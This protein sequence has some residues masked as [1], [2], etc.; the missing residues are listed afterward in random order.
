MQKN[1]YWLLLLFLIGMYQP[2]H[3]QNPIMA[4]IGMSDPHIR[5]FNDTV[6]LYCGHDSGPD[7][8]TW[9]MRDWRVFSTTDLVSW[10]FKQT[11]SPKDNYMDDNST[12]CWAGDAAT[13][14]GRYYFYFSDRKRGVGVMRS[15]SPKGPFRDALGKPL[16]SPMHDPTILIDDDAE[17][18]PYLIYG[19][20]EGGG[21][22]VARLN[23]D[24]ISVAEI[25]K[26]VKIIGEEWENAPAWMDKNYIFKHNGVYYLSWG[27]DYAISENVYGPYECAGSVGEGHHLSE[28]A[29]GSFFW[30]KGQF[31]HIWCYYLRQGYKY[32]ES[33]ITYC[34]FDENGAIVTD[35]DF[36]DKHFSTGVGRYDASWPEIQAEWY[37]EIS[38]GI[39]KQGSREEGFL[40]K[41]IK[42]G[43][44][45]RY[46]NVNFENKCRSFE[47]AV[48]LSGEPGQIEI[49]TGSP[50]GKLL[51]IIS[52]RPPEYLKELQVVSC[53]LNGVTGREDIV[54]KFTGDETSTFELDWFRF[55][56]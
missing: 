3:G 37:Y 34:H 7:D 35:T 41:D 31:Y 24:M 52:M 32:R 49:R 43:D 9:I 21:F 38:P 2:G 42:N 18:T 50:E 40:L 22:H 45:L 17:S 33:I 29:H 25:P 56:D 44:W 36:L 20:K 13:R 48:S 54:L 19:D 47:A 5:V 14:D 16:V 15:G 30:W 23:E 26:P 12:D 46:T 51:G 6:F 53:E 8:P 27:K 55:H 4:D 39:V 1:K 28:Y 10:T 11:I